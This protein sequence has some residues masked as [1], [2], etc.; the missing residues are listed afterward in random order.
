MKPFLSRLKLFTMNFAADIVRRVR[1][2]TRRGV[3]LTLAALPVLVLLYV[4][5]LIPFTPSIVDISKA[6]SQQPARVLSVDGKELAV[7]QRANR[8]W[9]KLADISPNVIAA[10]IS[11]EDHRFYEH[12]GVDLK[13]TASAVLHTFGGD[14]QG[15]STITQQLARN[16]YPD[17]VGRAQTLTRKIKELITALKIES[18]YT[19][20]EI[21]ETYLNT[22]PFLYNAYGIEMAARTYFDKSA[23]QLDVLESATLIGMLKGTS[24]YNP[25][26]N[27]ERATQRRNIVLAQ[28]VKGNKLAAADYETLKKRPLKIDFERQNEP[29]GP[30]GAEQPPGESPL[31]VVPLML[32]PESVPVKS[33]KTAKGEGSTVSCTPSCLGPR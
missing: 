15:G 21:L 24:Y 6:K 2:P 25:V 30:D 4:L 27:P 5:V 11:T 32:T 3:A 18:V 8:N 10:L 23:D 22:V 1:H 31:S 33:L 19:K 14:T 28:M 13:R 9:V 16:L 29:L 7:F 26:I 12:H 20:N 17:Q